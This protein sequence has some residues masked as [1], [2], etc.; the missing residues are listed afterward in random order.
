MPPVHAMTLCLCG[1]A[2]DVVCALYRVCVWQ[3]ALLHATRT[4]RSDGHTV[5]ASTA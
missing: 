5:H 3:V 2:S 1:A 4:M